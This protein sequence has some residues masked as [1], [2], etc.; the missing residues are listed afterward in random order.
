MPSTRRPAKFWLAVF[1][2]LLA[3]IPAMAQQSQLQR[4]LSLPRGGDP[5]LAEYCEGIL[6]A[7]GNNG[8]QNPA[9]AFQHYF[10]AAE[11]GSADGQAAVGAAY[12]RGWQVQ[13]DPAQ[14]AQWYGKAAAQGHAGA[15]L[16]LGQMY[17]KGDG[18]AKDPAKARQLIAAAAGQ[19]FAPAREALA[20]LDAGGPRPVPGADLWSQAVARYRSGDHAGA[21]K[22]A[23]QAA[24]Q[25]H[26][27]AVYQ[28]GYLYENGDGVVASDAEALRWYRTGAERGIAASQAALGQFYE[29]GRG[30]P[31]D[32]VTAA[33]W[34]AKSARQ[35][36]RTGQFRLGRAYEYGIG[37]PLSLDQAIA[38][39]DK[40]AAQGDSQAAAQ[41]RYLRDNHGVD[42]SSRNARE[43]AQLG[44]LILRWFA[45]HP[46]LGVVFHNNAERVAFIS[47]VASGETRSR[48]QAVHDMQQ[49]DYNACRA[50]GGD[51]CHAPVTPAPR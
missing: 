3:A 19:G 20:E 29:E 37:V 40:A 10:K 39:Y 23:R 33:G 24:D 18:V 34:Y 9:A 21:A 15:E 43:Q 38:W 16:S 48:Q 51:D 49:G 35:D 27:T 13:S 1:L 41:A 44:P 47:N 11:M 5:A 6:A 17:A 42:G 45:E 22:L 26:P 25:G 14:A 32:W 4:C 12:Q 30:V 46:P 28:M 36:N 31:D 7:N 2:G 8:P 50:R